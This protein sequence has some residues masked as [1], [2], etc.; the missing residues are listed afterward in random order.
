MFE[1]TDDDRIWFHA[2]MESRMLESLR[3]TGID[4]PLFSLVCNGLYDQ[5]KEKRTYQIQHVMRYTALL[6]NRLWTKIRD[7]NEEVCQDHLQFG[8]G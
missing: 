7:T 2:I 1:L 6:S 4:G 5:P 8:L 3:A